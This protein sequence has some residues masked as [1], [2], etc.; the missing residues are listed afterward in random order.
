MTS[1][2]PALLQAFFHQ[3]LLTERGLAENTIVSY[4]DAL[5]L[6]L[7]YLSERL[8]KSPDDLDLHDITQQSVLDFLDHGET[9]RGWTAKSRNQRLSGIRCF[10]RYI[11]RE[12]PD[13][14]LQAQQ[15]RS[16][17]YKKTEHRPPDSL[18][19]EE[20]RALLDAVDQSSDRGGRDYALLLTLYNTGA[21]VSEIAGLAPHDL[22]L[23]GSAQVKIMGKGRKQRSCP[24]WPETV[25]ALKAWLAVR[26]PKDPDDTALFLNAQGK[27]LT[28]YGV[29]Y[30]LN[31]HGM[32]AQAKCPSIQAKALTPHLIRHTT[33]MHLIRSGNDITN[34][35]SWLGHASLTTTHLYVEIDM[36]TKRQMLDKTPAPPSAS[37]PPWRRPGILDWLDSFR[38]APVAM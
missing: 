13:L 8:H 15:I 17:G 12:R 37:P 4:R 19:D 34:V 35:A 1:S 22:R 24:L 18:E 5:K 2:L 26:R 25:D 36:E 7:R 9:V 11:A 10:W 3:Y 20:M 27:G 16:I 33:A 6:L 14:M 32:T 30:I 28:R 21:R 29:R 38:L 23:D 31:K